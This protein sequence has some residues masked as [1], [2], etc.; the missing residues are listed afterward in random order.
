MGMRKKIVIAVMGLALFMVGF[1]LGGTE[2]WAQG[3]IKADPPS[4]D[5]APPA[6]AAV[7]IMGSGFKAEDRVLIVLAGADKG[8]DVPVAFAEADASGAFEAKM[9]MLSILQG[10]LHFRF[11]EGKPLP[12]PNNPPLPPGSYTLRASS[13]DSGLEAKCSFEI[14]APSK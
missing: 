2:A 6:L 12:D 3:S 10:I 8:Q 14:K 4:A 7:K 1:H 13:R 11:K 9:E 5:L